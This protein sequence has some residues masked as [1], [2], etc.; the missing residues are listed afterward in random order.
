V[1]KSTLF[2]IGSS[3]LGDALST[4][5]L[6][7]LAETVS[8][9]SGLSDPFGAATLIQLLCLCAYGNIGIRWIMLVIGRFHCDS[10]LDHFLWLFCP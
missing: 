7:A 4:A 3:T 6:A 2:T 10:S 1:Y 8:V 5:G 9:Q